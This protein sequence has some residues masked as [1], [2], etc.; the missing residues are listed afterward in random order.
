MLGRGCTHLAL[1]AQALTSTDRGL[2]I[3]IFVHYRQR[4][5]KR[6]DMAYRKDPDLEFLKNVPSANLNELVDYLTKDKDGNLRLTEELTDNSR[7]KSDCPDHHQ[8]WDL[9]AAELQY[10]GANT[11][12]TILRGGEGVPYREILTDVCNK[13]KV[14][15][16]QAARV[17]AIEMNLLMK[18]LTDSME[19][20]SPD[21]LK[22]VVE[23]L[24]L[25]TTDFTGPA[26]AAALQGAVFYSGFAAYQMATIVANAVAKQLLGRGLTIAANATLTRTIGMFAGP[27]GWALTGLWTIIIIA[28]PAYRVTIPAVI[29]VAYLRVKTQYES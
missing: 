11:I 28:G 16:N 14:N 23:E 2:I 10:F 8:Y 1:V 13:M 21:D 18:V 25:N 22:A 15:Y 3:K 27:I 7:Y 29:Q 4:A 6:D 5:E 26:V 19:K 12:A 24:N 17:G 20:M 9:I